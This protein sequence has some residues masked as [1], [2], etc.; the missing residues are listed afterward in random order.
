MPLGDKPRQ[1]V[2]VQVTRPPRRSLPRDAFRFVPRASVHRRRD[3]EVDED[4][5][6]RVTPAE[7]FQ[8]GHGPTHPFPRGFVLSAAIGGDRLAHERYDGSRGLGAVVEQGCDAS[9]EAGKGRVVRRRGVGHGQVGVDERHARLRKVLARERGDFLGFSI[10]RWVSRDGC[11]PAV[12]ARVT[13][14]AASMVVNM[15]NARE[16]AGRTLFA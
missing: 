13:K 7:P 9:L 2:G 12:A 11:P 5:A 10:P 16:A 8:V 14:D 1:P 6:L 4:V 3:C 15:G